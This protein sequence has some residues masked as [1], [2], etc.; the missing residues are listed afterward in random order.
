[1]SH[2][3]MSVDT[4]ASI[5]GAHKNAK[6]LTSSKSSSLFSKLKIGP[7]IYTGFGLVLT[8]M[9][10]LGFFSIMELRNLDD[11]FLKYEDMAGDSRLVSDIQRSVVE[12]QLAAREFLATSDTKEKSLFETNFA[13]LDALAKQAKGEIFKPERV[14]LLSRVSRQM[15]D[16]GQG[17]SEIAT[18]LDRRNELLYSDLSVSGMD[19]R[20][21][22]TQIREGAFDA[23]DYESA[24]LAGV[25]QEHLLLAR[26][27]VMKFLDDNSKESMD[28]ANQELAAL[29]QKLTDL[30]ASLENPS[31][32]A[33]LAK[34]QKSAPKYQASFNELTEIIFRRNKI[35]KTIL[36]N[37][38]TQMMANTNAIEASA[39]K[40]EKILLQD[41]SDTLLDAE[42]A[43]M[44]V[45]ALAVLFGLIAAFVI[46][47]GITRPVLDL[48]SVMDKL[49]RNDFTIHVPGKSR[50]DELGQMAGAV[51]V[52]KQ[53]GIR[54]REL[55]AEQAT[56]KQR[57]EEEKHA[58]MLQMADDFDSH[59]GGIVNAVSSASTELSTTARSMAD[60][61]EETSSQATAAS[62]ASEQTSSNVQTVATATEE[63]TS[64]IAE[65]SQQ[66]VQASQSA[67]DA[68]TK[69]DET[70]GQMQLLAETAN[71]I[72]EVVEMI[73]TIAEQTN[74][75]ALN[76]TI[77]S[78]RA[79]EAGKGFAVVAGEV[80][81]LAGQTAKAT[82][83]IAQQITGIQNATQQA[84]LSMEQ[85]SHVIQQVDEISS[86]I[87]AAMEEQNAATHEIADSIHQAA[88][89][90]QVVNDN[91]RA[92]SDASQEAGAAS[93][94]V[95]SAAG[96]LA[97]QASILKD[98]V[99]KFI[100]QVRAS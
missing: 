40:D 80:K 19:I 51:E 35:R 7:R 96:E 38:A 59:V 13:K 97:Q 39:Q 73:S 58:M 76:A 18:L 88:E 6:D 57:A 33:L 66:V 77:E 5:D 86:A 90:T 45:G 61:S 64:T 23:N 29:G 99:G 22:L 14:E 87:A 12:T 93:A 65:I 53:N 11:S 46:S 95:Q 92:V 17:F 4:R 28:R 26:L 79:G 27:Y 9:V 41:V 72:G 10:G 49:A 78:A 71:K 48:T 3:S 84:T 89:G 54:A 34:V 81:D 85:V 44:I 68:V 25:A 70:N 43:M 94:Q 47:R 2:N 24:S 100:Q 56:A 91:V 55:E 63:M 16:Y 31:R 36:D 42:N 15:N 21:W 82:D 69:V 37:G 30:G 60:V 83:E 62:A 74:L 98:E 50:G 32:R 20:I 67:R 1:M 75:L 52:F 8:T